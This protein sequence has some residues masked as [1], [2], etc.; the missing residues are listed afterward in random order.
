MMTDRNF[1]LRWAHLGRGRPRS[2]R[3][4]QIIDEQRRT[5]DAHVAEIW[6]EQEEENKSVGDQ[7]LACCG[8]S[9]LSEGNR[10][11]LRSRGVGHDLYRERTR[12]AAIYLTPSSVCSSR[13]PR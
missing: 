6:A 8:G 1:V 7:L 2:L 4:R 11:P 5:L 3:H 9:S 10:A 12:R 13:G